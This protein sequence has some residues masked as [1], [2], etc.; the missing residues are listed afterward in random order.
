MLLLV[1]AL[2]AAGTAGLASLLVL[3]GASTV[4]ATVAALSQTVVKAPAQDP[5]V[6]PT[7]LAADGRPVGTDRW[8]GR[9]SVIF[10]GYTSCPDVCPMTLHA[11]TVVARDPASGVSAGTTQLVFVSVDPRRDTPA[12]LRRYL[13]PFGGGVLGVTGSPSAIDRFRGALGA[14]AL[15]LGAAFDHSTS[16]FVLDPAGRPAGLL[17]RPTEPARIVADLTSLRGARSDDGHHS[18]R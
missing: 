4:P 5:L 17:L 15:A 8:R 13:A 11:L 3:S 1:L 10:M 2:A 16:L 18:I 6:L 12:R 9:W 7:L 14:G